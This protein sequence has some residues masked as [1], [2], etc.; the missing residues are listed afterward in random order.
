MVIMEDHK[1]LSDCLDELGEMNFQK[2]C[3]YLALILNVK[4]QEVVSA[5]S[6]KGIFYK[7]GITQ[8][9]RFNGANHLNEINNRIELLEGLSQILL[10]EHDSDIFQAMKPYFIKST[11]AELKLTDFPYLHEDTFNIKT[12]LTNLKEGVTGVNIMVYS[13]PG[14][15]KTQWVK[16][17]I[18]SLQWQLFEVTTEDEEGE[19]QENRLNSYRLSQ[20]VLK[21]SKGKTAILVDEAEDIFPASEFDFFGILMGQKNSGSGIGKGWMNKIL[22]ENPVPTFWI[23]NKINQID[24]AYMRRFDYVIEL[25]RPPRNIRETMIRSYLDGV[26]NISQSLILQVA[27]HKEITPAH[28]AT[29]AKVIKGISL[30]FE[31]DK[32]DINKSIIHLFNNILN[33]QE[34][35]QLSLRDDKYDTPYELSFLNTDINIERLVQGVKKSKQGRFCLWG[36][37]GTGKTAFAQHLGDVLAIEVITKRASDL[38]E[39]YVGMTEKNIAKA[40]KEARQSGAILQIDEADSFLS[41]RQQAHRSW[42]VTQVN[43]MLTQIENFDGIV[44]MS[45]NLV[46]NLDDASIRR[47]DMK[48]HFDYMSDKQIWAMYSRILQI[49][50]VVLDEAQQIDLWQEIKPLTRTT[51]GDFSTCLRKARVSG[52]SITAESLLN[53]LKTELKFKNKFQQDNVTLRLAS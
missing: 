20:E 44:I 11:V 33:A 47:F 13:P 37:P 38:L 25:P 48:I 24:P 41:N 3:S 14:L 21:G 10:Q 34:S 7:A 26:Q 22:E 35:A 42:E 15:G 39:P 28:I 40:F 51:P 43:E 50:G 4:E 53:N 27:D 36:Q 8:K 19:A 46:E 18:E 30:G 9:P 2:T 49:H 31:K 45:T 5:F 32:L 23:T 6:R 52:Q 17:I 16:A 29:V 12:Y 1:S